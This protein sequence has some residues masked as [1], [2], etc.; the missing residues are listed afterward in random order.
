MWQM[1]IGNDPET[2]RQ[3]ASALQHAGVHGAPPVGPRLRW[4]LERWRC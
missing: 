2:V 3:R 1:I 4:Q